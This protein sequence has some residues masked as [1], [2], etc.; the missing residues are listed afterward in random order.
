M[1]FPEDVAH[2]LGYKL[3]KP[4]FFL[5][6]RIMTEVVRYITR[7]PNLYLYAVYSNQAISALYYKVDIPQHATQH[8]TT[9][10]QE[11]WTVTAAVAVLYHW[12]HLGF[13]AGNIALSQV[14]TYPQ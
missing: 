13:T 5:G 10:H 14:T 1:C 7:G 11:E 8:H 6:C 12:Y 3:V 9:P 4:C 2:C